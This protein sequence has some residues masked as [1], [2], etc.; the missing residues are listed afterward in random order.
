MAI[1]IASSRPISALKRMCDVVQKTV[2][3]TIVTAVKVTALPE[4]IERL[5]HASP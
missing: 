3:M 5:A 2:L 1:Q 4:V